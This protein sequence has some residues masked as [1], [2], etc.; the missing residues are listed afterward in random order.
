VTSSRGEAEPVITEEQAWEKWQEVG[1]LIEVLVARSDTRGE[2]DAHPWSCLAADDRASDPYQVSHAVSQCLMAGIDHAHAVKSLVVDH[3]ELHVAAPASLARGFIENMA[4]AFWIL[5]P[6]QRSDR[7]LHAAQWHAQNVKDQHRALTGL[8]RVPPP[9]RSEAVRIARL[10][11]IAERAGNKDAGWLRRGYRPT[12]PV[13]YAEAHGGPGTK[14]VLLS[15]QLGSGFAH[16]RPWA[17]LGM[18]EQEVMTTE[19]SSVL[20]VRLTNDFARSLFP[21]LFGMHLAQAV[22][23]LRQRRARPLYM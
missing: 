19:G 13:E 23:D 12:E 11:G 4:A 16:G 17:F 1:R 14:G 18:L 6:D 15:W 8:E 21:V 20:D 2:W 9:A 5:H 3:Q 7:V 10:V 22:L